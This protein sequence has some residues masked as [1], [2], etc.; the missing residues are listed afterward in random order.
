MSKIGKT[1]PTVKG[2]SG[3]LLNGGVDPAVGKA[4]QI[5]PGEVR[6]PGGRP[7]S[8]PITTA[9]AALLDKKVDKDPQGRTYAELLAEGQFRA[10]IIGE[11]SAAREI[12]NRLEGPVTAP[13]EEFEGSE[14]EFNLTVRF[15]DVADKKPA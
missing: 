13:K 14:L 1:A 12:T 3:K 11:T 5:Q 2:T 8:K 6:N 15:R 9:Y 7:K 4:T 10:A